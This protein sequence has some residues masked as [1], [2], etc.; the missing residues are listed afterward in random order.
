MSAL[1]A[2]SLRHMARQLSWPGYAR[3]DPTFPRYFSP[4]HRNIFLKGIKH[5]D[6]TTQD[7]KSVSGGQIPQ[8]YRD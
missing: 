1:L 8:P 7:R 5:G 6:S 4:G 3:T 2:D